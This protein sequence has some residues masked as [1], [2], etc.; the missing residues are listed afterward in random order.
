MPGVVACCY[1]FWFETFAVVHSGSFSGQKT[2]FQIAPAIRPVLVNAAIRRRALVDRIPVHTPPAIAPYGFR[3][4]APAFFIRQPLQN[5]V[6]EGTDLTSVPA[7]PA[8]GFYRSFR[9]HS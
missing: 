2:N 9:C 4:I 1:G 5:A 6:R 7:I 8:A 3:S